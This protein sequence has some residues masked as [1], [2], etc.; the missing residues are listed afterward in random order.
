[1]LS[2]EKVTKDN[3][4]GVSLS[5]ECTLE[6]WNAMTN[7]PNKT[8]ITSLSGNK[9]NEQLGLHDHSEKKHKCHILGRTEI[10]IKSKKT[11]M[12]SP[13]KDLLLRIL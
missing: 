1:M 12:L 11:K 8:G 2:Q 6:Q 10:K 5:A 9:N 13:L 4:N 3:I 7:S